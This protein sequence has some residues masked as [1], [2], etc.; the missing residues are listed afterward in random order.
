MAY[1]K[2]ETTG[3]W[4]N[5]ETFLPTRERRR[6]ASWLWGLQRRPSRMR[7]SQL[8][9]VNL[10]VLF[11]PWVVLSLLTLALLQ[12]DPVAALTILAVA[13]IILVCVAGTSSWFAATATRLWE[14][15]CLRMDLGSALV[16]TMLS[17]CFGVDSVITCA[18]LVFVLIVAA[19]GPRLF[20]FCYTWQQASEED[21]QENL[22]E[23][24]R[25]APPE[26]DTG[27]CCWDLAHEKQVEQAFRQR[28]VLEMLVQ[29]RW[30]FYV[31]LTA[32][33]SVALVIFP[34]NWLMVA[35]GGL[36]LCFFVA[37]AMRFAHRNGEECLE[38]AMDDD[39]RVM[40]FSAI[41]LSLLPV[42]LGLACIWFW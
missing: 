17:V 35:A 29:I 26:L 40:H 6:R 25:F 19:A 14:I 33:L 36:V 4:Q 1:I 27:E 15:A 2:D 12:T 24:V 23:L 38:L 39:D 7:L 28:M 32:F 13:A 5:V 11:Q 8:V 31:L 41:A 10:L 18:Y 42:L 30:V 21:Q 20:D 37:R 9:L 22:L 16:M 34:D 3:K